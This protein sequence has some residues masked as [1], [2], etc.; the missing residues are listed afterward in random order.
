MCLPIFVPN[1]WPTFSAVNALVK[2]TIVNFQGKVKQGMLV[3]EGSC[4]RC[5][6]DVERVID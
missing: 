3:L 5:G 2:L 1:F 6:S 4:Q